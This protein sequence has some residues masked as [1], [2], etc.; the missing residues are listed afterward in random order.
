MEKP[1]RS[2][3]QLSKHNFNTGETLEVY[4]KLVKGRAEAERMVERF[5][6]ERL[7]EEEDEAGVAW[8]L[9]KTSK[10]RL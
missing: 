9:Q 6:R 8:Y 3:Y 5:Q 10:L 1:D 2:T 7:T 4:P